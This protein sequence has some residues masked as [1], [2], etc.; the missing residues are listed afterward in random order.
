MG[1]VGW[2]GTWGDAVVAAPLAGSL[3]TIFC[4]IFLW[5]LEPAKH[6]TFIIVHKIHKSLTRSHK[7]TSS[8]LGSLIHLPSL[9]GSELVEGLGSSPS[10]CSCPVLS[11]RPTTSLLSTLWESGLTSGTSL[12]YNAQKP[13]TWTKNGY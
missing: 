12:Q 11:S 8:D 5:G 6:I 4:I 10:P 2:V 7:Y 9:V 13:S 3:H 1:G